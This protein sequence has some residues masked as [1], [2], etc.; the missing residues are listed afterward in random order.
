L[1]L[2]FILKSQEIQQQSCFLVEII[3]SE[4][5]SQLFLHFPVSYLSIVSSI[6]QIS[7]KLLADVFDSFCVLITI[8]YEKL[9]PF[10]DI[11]IPLPLLIM[12][13]RL[14]RTFI[15][16]IEPT[17]VPSVDIPNIEKILLIFRQ[18]QMLI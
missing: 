7:E 18:I 1:L 8:L 3:T 6:S 13:N 14:K 11:T 10:D 2:A 15:E 9:L 16:N 12:D 5:T 4:M 17:S